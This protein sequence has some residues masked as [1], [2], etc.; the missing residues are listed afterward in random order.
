MAASTQQI[1]EHHLKCFGEGDLEGILGDYTETSV[2]FT[3][4][5]ILRGSG[6]MRGLFEAFFAE[7]AKPGAS[8]EMKK[9]LVDGETAY[10]VWSAE[11]ADNVYELATDTFVVRDGKIVAQTLAGKIVP[12]G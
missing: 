1:L 9:Q 10:I 12:K 4:D 2:L 5:G 8:F 11:T 6:E 3:P 7:F